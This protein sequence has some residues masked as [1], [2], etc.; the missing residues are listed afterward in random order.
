M[1]L[2]QLKIKLEKREKAFRKKERI[3]KIN[4]RHVQAKGISYLTKQ[5]IK[6]KKD[7]PGF[8]EKLSDDE[9]IRYNVLRAKSE[10]QRGPSGAFGEEASPYLRKAFDILG[11]QAKGIA[12]TMSFTDEKGYNQKI[13]Q[14]K[15]VERMSEKYAASLLSTE[16]TSYFQ[17][18]EVKA[19]LG[20][21]ENCEEQIVTL[22]KMWKSYHKK[23]K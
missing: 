18:R 6:E 17:L 8:Y 12:Q 1:N 21:A 3:E 14:I 11:S 7:S 20:V 13:R 10:M 22:N 19:I 23:K 15:A 4:R 5:E 9:K 2:Q 16:P